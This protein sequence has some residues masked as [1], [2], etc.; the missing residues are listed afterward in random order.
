MKR[1]RY[2][3]TCDTYTLKTKCANGHETATTAPPKYSP[4]DKY[5]SY[6]REAKRDERKRKGLL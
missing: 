1:I 5:T 6:R 3:A 4:D 2:C